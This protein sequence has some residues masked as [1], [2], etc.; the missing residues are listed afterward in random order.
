MGERIGGRR[1]FLKEDIEAT[2][3]DGKSER[4]ERDVQTLR[5]DNSSTL[6]TF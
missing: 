2:D 3:T 6:L 4:G 1:V 5:L